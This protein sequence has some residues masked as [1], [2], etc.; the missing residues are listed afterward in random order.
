MLL[1][2]LLTILVI[3]GAVLTLRMRRGQV[4][5][6]VSSVG[7]KRR[8]PSQ[9]KLDTPIKIVAAGLAVLMVIGVSA[10][11]YHQW[12]DSYRVVTIRVI[13]TRS[14]TASQYEAYKGDVDGRQFVTTDGRTVALAEVERMELGGD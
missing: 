1:K 9:R 10:Y 8:N 7:R 6:P 4:E 2:I 14:G 5:A 13:D 11:L 12:Q 3:A